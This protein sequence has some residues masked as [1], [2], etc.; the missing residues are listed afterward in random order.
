MS[1]TSGMGY[2]VNGWNDLLRTSQES[3]FA[4]FSSHKA[5][6]W[7]RFAIFQAAGLARPDI[8]FSGEAH[9]D[10]SDAANCRE[11]LRRSSRM[12]LVHDGREGGNTFEAI[13]MGHDQRI[14]IREI[15]LGL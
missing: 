2:E 13:R 10:D 14:T 5:I 9:V 6:V 7:G 15:P 11:Q 8:S 4:F 1:I 12:I 3:E